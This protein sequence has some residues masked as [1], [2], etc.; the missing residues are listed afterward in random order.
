MLVGAAALFGFGLLLGFLL[1]RTGDEDEPSASPVTPASP[2]ATATQPAVLT[3]PPPVEAPAISTEGQVLQ[4]GRTVIAAPSNAACTALLSPGTIGDCNEVVVAGQRV[5]WIVEQATTPTG[6]AAF[7]VRIST[8]VPDEGG[9]VQWLEASD[10]AGERWSDVNVL[11]ADLTSDGVA[12]LLVGFRSVGEAQSLEYDVVGY[13]ESAVP[14]VLAHPEPATRGS[15]IV[16][17]GTIQ[18]YGAQYPNDEPLCCP[19]SYR[20][21]TIA[22]EDSFFRVIGSEAVVTTAVPPSQL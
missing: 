4:D 13:S 5:V 1:G 22:F 20:R 17:A 14:E 7:S 2:T 15:V 11:A 18:E 21:R 19:P 16:S 8:F 9:W 12:E 10:P 6:A 3:T